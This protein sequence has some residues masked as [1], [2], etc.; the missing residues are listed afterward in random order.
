MVTINTSTSFSGGPKSEEASSEAESS[1]LENIFASIFSLNDEKNSSLSLGLEATEAT[2][3]ASL[4]S[5]IKK[6]LGDKKNELNS[7]ISGSENSEI[8]STNVLKIYES[9]KTL[10]D[11]TTILES[12]PTIS[13]SIEDG[14]ELALEKNTLAS[15]KVLKE[16]KSSILLNQI[17]AKTVDT[18]PQPESELSFE[19]FSE[20]E[21]A[22]LKAN[23]KQSS[24]S[25][26]DKENKK[27][28][29]KE[30]EGKSL[31][32]KTLLENKQPQA[33]FSKGTSPLLTQNNRLEIQSGQQANTQTIE[34]LNDQTSSSSRLGTLAKANSF[35]LNTQ[36]NQ[37]LHQTQLK[38][39][40]KNWGTDLAKIIE[41][42]L[43]SGKEKINISLDPQKLGKMHLTLSVV[44][45][46]T[47]IIINT[48]NTAASLILSGAEERLSQM[49]EA[50]GLKLSNFQT[51][52]NNGNS[53]KNN[54]HSKQNKNAG[55]LNKSS[56]IKTK[57]TENPVIT[58]DENGRKIINL[59]A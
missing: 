50:S 6:Q 15:S 11:E 5:E 25:A 23:L 53:G 52:S 13:F 28:D 47:S 9:F 44:N 32:I 38:I 16:M 39:L 36:S 56:D 35:E 40:E 12:D 34:H 41:K 26:I 8:F 17:A 37:N 51:N 55:S 30:I 21:M 19:E 24:E 42:A 2:E 29:K 20:A 54:S 3:A 57:P 33:K 18:P 48:E 7:G 43:A 4:L 14:P 58:Q 1:G 49:F 59:I 10:I 45:N 27:K 22:R 46:Q 31:G